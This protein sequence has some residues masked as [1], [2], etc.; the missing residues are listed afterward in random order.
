[1][2]NLVTGEDLSRCESVYSPITD[3]QYTPPMEDLEEDFSPLMTSTMIVPEPVAKKAF[4][5]DMEGYEALEAQFHFGFKEDSSNDSLPK[6]SI[7]YGLQ[8]YCRRSVYS[9][10][11]AMK[12]ISLVKLNRTYAIRLSTD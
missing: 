4:E 3:A 10:Y 11:K 6:F 7:D 8:P 5:H 2:I 1:M 12:G 9:S